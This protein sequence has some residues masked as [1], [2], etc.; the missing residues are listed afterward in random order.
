M[1]EDFKGV[2]YTLFPK[3]IKYKRSKVGSKMTTYGITLQVA[4][5]TG[6]TAAVFRADMAERWQRLIVKTGGTLFD[7]PFIPFGKEGDTGGDVITTFIQ[8]HHTFLHETKQCFVQNM[9]DIDCLIIHSY[10]Q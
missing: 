5:T 2:Q 4:E 3:T 9:N 7:K 6:I 8:Q 1:V 10:R